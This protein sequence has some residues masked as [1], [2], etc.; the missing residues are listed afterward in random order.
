MRTRQTCTK[1]SLSLSPPPFNYVISKIWRFFPK[2][3]VQVVKFIV[4]YLHFFPK[5]FQYFWWKNEKFCSQKTHLQHVRENLKISTFVQ[6]IGGGTLWH[7]PFLFW[8]LIPFFQI[9]KWMHCFLSNHP[10]GQLSLLLACLKS[11]CFSYTMSFHYTSKDKSFFYLSS[12]QINR[13][14]IGHIWS[15]WFSP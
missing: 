8:H 4:K 10:R 2:I 14:E 13:N 5:T 7:A 3:L 12:T 11:Y 6:T 1:G 15:N 9:D